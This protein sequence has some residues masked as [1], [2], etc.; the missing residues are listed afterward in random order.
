MT[1]TTTTRLIA[2]LHNQTPPRACLS[3]TR[4]ECSTA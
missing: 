3:L 1:I 4:G 2:R